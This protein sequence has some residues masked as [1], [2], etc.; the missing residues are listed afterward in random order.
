MALTTAQQ[1]LA[2]E[3]GALAFQEAREAAERAGTPLEGDLRQDAQRYAE[4]AV[5]RMLTDGFDP[6]VDAPHYASEYVRDSTLS[7]LP[8]GL[9][10]REAADGAYKRWWAHTHRGIRRGVGST[11]A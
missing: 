11:P 1:D 3:Q 5:N 10:T 4:D 2:D 9:R 7:R 6:T 8:L